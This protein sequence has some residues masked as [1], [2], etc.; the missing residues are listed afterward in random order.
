LPDAERHASPSPEEPEHEAQGEDSRLASTRLI[1]VLIALLLALV[2]VPL[3]L[4]TLGIASG[5]R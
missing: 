5:A 4:W 1:G 2:V 3:L